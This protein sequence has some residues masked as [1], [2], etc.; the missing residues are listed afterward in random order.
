MNDK[1]ETVKKRIKKDKE[2]LLEQLKKTP[3]S[4]ACLRKDW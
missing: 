1:L 2:L 4:A 3:I